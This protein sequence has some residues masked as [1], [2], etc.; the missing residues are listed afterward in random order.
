MISAAGLGP[1]VRWYGNILKLV[2]DLEAIDLRYWIFRSCLNY[3]LS[4]FFFAGFSM[5][6]F[7]NFQVKRK[8]VVSVCIIFRSVIRYVADAINLMT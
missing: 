4:D 6:V 2:D 7:L 1:N 5:R 3:R 8:I